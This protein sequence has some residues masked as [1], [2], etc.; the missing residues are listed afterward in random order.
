MHTVQHDVFHHHSNVQYWNP[1]LVRVKHPWQY[2]LDDLIPMRQM[3]QLHLE[4]M[5]DVPTAH[6]SHP[7]LH[8]QWSQI[9]R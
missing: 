9:H 2:P 6:P 8:S 3:H 5:P 1:H 7:Y 4:Q